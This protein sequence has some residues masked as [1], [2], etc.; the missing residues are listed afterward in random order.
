MN[1]DVNPCE[2]F[3]EYVCGNF[4]KEHPRSDSQFTHD[5][6]LEKQTSVLRDVK[7]K[8]ENLTRQFSDASSLNNIPKPLQKVSMLYQSCTDTGTIDKLKIKPLQDFLAKLKLPTLPSLLVKSEENQQEST[9]ETTF[10]WLYPVVHMK[11]STG[12]D[13]LFGFEVC[14]SLFMFEWRYRSL[15]F[16]RL[17]SYCVSIFI[18]LCLLSASQSR[19]PKIIRRIIWLLVHRNKRITCHCNDLVYMGNNY[20]DV[21]SDKY[22]CAYSFQNRRTFNERLESYSTKE[23]ESYG[24]RQSTCE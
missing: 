16:R 17:L 14:T 10:N 1:L 12:I 5:W 2:N 9:N 19:I 18:L 21:I 22:V 4:D 11:R 23:K 13:K 6:F 24:F 3:Y 20:L 8:L 15:N 7:R